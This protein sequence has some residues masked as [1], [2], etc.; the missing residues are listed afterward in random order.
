MTSV[1]RYTRAV[2]LSLL[3]FCASLSAADGVAWLSGPVLQWSQIFIY[4]D[5]TVRKALTT[6]LQ[7][8]LTK[9]GDPGTVVVNSLV[10]RTAEPLIGVDV[11]YTV[12]GSSLTDEQLLGVFSRSPLT[13]LNKDIGVTTG[14]KGYTLRMLP[15]LPSQA[16][17][18]STAADSRIAITGSSLMWKI[19][20]EKASPI[21]TNGI[22]GG[23]QEDFQRAIDPDMT[24][25]A[26]AATI[27]PTDPVT[28]ASLFIDYEVFLINPVVSSP[29][30]QAQMNASLFVPTN[31]TNAAMLL[32]LVRSTTEFKPY[33][34]L[35]PFTLRAH[36]APKERTEPE[37]VPEEQITSSNSTN[38]ILFFSGSASGWTLATE[39]SD[40][41]KALIKQAAELALAREHY[42]YTVDVTGL[43][44]VTEA[45]A[46]H[47]NVGMKAYATVT[48]GMSDVARYPYDKEALASM[49]S[50]G[51]YSAVIALYGG[52][53]S[54]A[55]LVAVANAEADDKRKLTKSEIA[56]IIMGAVIVGLM[57]ITF[58]I[59][60][61]VVC[62]CCKE[63][64]EEDYDDMEREMRA[65]GSS[66]G[67]N[68]RPS[69]AASNPFTSNSQYN[70]LP[71]DDDDEADDYVYEEEDNY[72]NPKGSSYTPPSAL[73]PPVLKSAL[74]KKGGDLPEAPV[75]QDGGSGYAGMFGNAPRREV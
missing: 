71:E 25:Y 6:D 17:L 49:V 32:N 4:T 16:T 43:E 50:F 22:A 34:D 65:R 67:M 51:D 13:E 33:E 24:D 35:F 37:P 55:E 29:M 19:V 59:V 23:L 31:Y 26:V 70:R 27:P 48:Q 14:M 21:V 3:L 8:Q 73:P 62:C 38:V 40:S 72:Y 30:T 52:A 12:T 1:T 56:M 15:I 69:V 39:Q 54:E 61:C 60:T 18:I 63:K 46:V 57:L 66:I 11:T 68:H 36:V 41:T 9:E 64:Y 74:K 58:I 2:L 7:T 10:A 53:T 28:A 20:F 47:G 42:K 75:R 45:D 44:T 5:Y